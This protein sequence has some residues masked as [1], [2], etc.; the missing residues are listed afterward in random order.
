M[1]K[2]LVIH[3]NKQQ[4]SSRSFCLEKGELY[5]STLQMGSKWQGWLAVGSPV[6]TQR[7]QPRVMGIERTCHFPTQTCRSL[8]QWSHEP[9]PGF[10]EDE[11]PEQPPVFITTVL[12][13]FFRYIT[14][15]KCMY[16]D[17]PLFRVVL[18][19][20]VPDS[21]V[22]LLCFYGPW[23]HS[24]PSAQRT[25]LAHILEALDPDSGKC[26]PC[27]VQTSAL[28]NHW[29]GRKWGCQKALS[30]YTLVFL[31]KI[32]MIYS[33]L[34]WKKSNINVSNTDLT[35]LNSSFGCIYMGLCILIS[36]LI[37]I[38]CLNHHYLFLYVRVY[39]G[40]IALEVDCFVISITNKMPRF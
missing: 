37:S 12:Q 38:I 22:L 26:L 28:W 6:F 15:Q 39:H 31:R 19:V 11:F 21:V 23:N 30:A 33:Q 17:A 16:S 32:F 2:A 13:G 8:K 20:C 3:G 5:L 27:H 14:E 29:H 18:C 35:T 9:L 25:E 1:K 40:A 34:D 7:A 24:G 4:G 10:H 36:M